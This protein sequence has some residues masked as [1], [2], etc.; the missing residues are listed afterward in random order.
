MKE[1]RKEG[2]KERKKETK[3]ERKK[4]RKG[5]GGLLKGGEIK[6]H[7]GLRRGDAK[8]RGQ[9]KSSSCWV[10]WLCFRISSWCSL[11]SV[12]E[13]PCVCC[14]CMFKVCDLSF[15][16]LFYRGDRRLLWVSEE[17]LN[18]GLLNMLRLTDSGNLKSNFRLDWMHFCI[19][20]ESFKSMGP[21]SEMW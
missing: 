16:L 1:G 11:S 8:C 2:R 12:L 10:S 6:E 19:K 14:H 4:E 20:I 15:H 21:E 5:G 18:F 13:W 7:V 9:C 17:T 3:K